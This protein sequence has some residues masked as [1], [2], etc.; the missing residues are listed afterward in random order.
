MQNIE[1]LQDIGAPSTSTT[2]VPAD[3]AVLGSLAAEDFQELQFVVALGTLTGTPKVIIKSS[4]TEGGTK[5]TE[6]EISLAAATYSDKTI[7][8]SVIAPL[9]AWYHLVLDRNSGT[10]KT[11]VVSVIG[12]RFGAKKEPFTAAGSY[13]FMHV[14]N[15]LP[16]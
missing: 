9:R 14:A 1:P 2:I 12:Q 16:S 13:G 3:A 5:T 10:F 4:D 8:V 6:L 11:A 7:N 15:T